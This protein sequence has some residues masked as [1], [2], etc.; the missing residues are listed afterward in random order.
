MN[1]NDTDYTESYQIVVCNIHWNTSTASRK[2]AVHDLPSQLALD[3]PESI[4]SQARKSNEFNDV[5]EQF[6][7]N[8]LTRKFMCECCSCQIWL[9]L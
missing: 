1:Y 8:L 4:L 2:T 3:I 5:I 9:P 6:T 7:Y